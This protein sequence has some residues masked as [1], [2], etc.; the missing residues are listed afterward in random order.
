MFDEDGDAPDDSVA[1]RA[2]PAEEPEVRL[3]VL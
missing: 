2:A 3:S 1:V